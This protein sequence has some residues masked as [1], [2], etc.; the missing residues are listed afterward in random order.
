MGFIRLSQ[1]FRG[2]ECP[3]E[4]RLSNTTTA[5][6]FILYGDSY[7]VFLGLFHTQL[8]FCLQ[9]YFLAACHRLYINSLSSECVS[10]SAYSCWCNQSRG[11]WEGRL[12]PV[13]GIDGILIRSHSIG[14]HIIPSDLSVRLINTCSQNKTCLF[15]HFMK[16]FSHV[17]VFSIRMSSFSI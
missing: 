3:S 1:L 7:R 14:W 4:R 2:A 12:W 8:L 5:P 10:P 15:L 16:I 6:P 13:C 9:V 17:A 11:K